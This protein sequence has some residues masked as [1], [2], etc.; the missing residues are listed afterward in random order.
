MAESSRRNRLNSRTVLALMLPVAA[1]GLCAFPFG[2][3]RGLNSVPFAD[4]GKAQKLTNEGNLELLSGQTM[5]GEEVSH[6]L[7]TGRRR[8][9]LLGP[10]AYSLRLV[11]QNP[12]AC[13]SRP[14]NSGSP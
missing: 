4:L 11:T 14:C 6:S 7:R 5:R 2:D 9:I 12:S 8:Q 1:L 3:N 13:R 10:V